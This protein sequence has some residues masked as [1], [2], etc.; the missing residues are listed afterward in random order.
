MCNLIG[1]DA[2][3]F[4]EPRN[5]QRLGHPIIRNRLRQQVPPIIPPSHNLRMASLQ[6]PQEIEYRIR[7]VTQCHNPILL[8]KLTRKIPPEDLF[9]LLLVLRLDCL[10]VLDDADSAGNALA[11]EDV[12]EQVPVVVEG[13]GFGGVQGQGLGV[14][15]FY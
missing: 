9:N 15:A 3:P 4:E 11:L 5:L 6:H 12:H 14:Y 13:V 8:A 7:A 2:I 10:E 1:I